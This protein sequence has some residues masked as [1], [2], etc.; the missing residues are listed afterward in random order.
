MITERFVIIPVERA[1]LIPIGVGSVNIDPKGHMAFVIGIDSFG[2][3]L[4]QK[5]RE[6]KIRALRISAVEVEQ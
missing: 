6:G 2:K 5:F 3:E 4:Q 1:G